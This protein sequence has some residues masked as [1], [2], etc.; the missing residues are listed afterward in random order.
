MKPHI[1]KGAMRL[2]STTEQIEIDRFN[3]W[4]KA[5]SNLH[6]VPSH[7]WQAYRIDC[8]LHAGWTRTPRAWKHEPNRTDFPPIDNPKGNHSNRQHRR[9]TFIPSRIETSMGTHERVESYTP[10]QQKFMDEARVMAERVSTKFHVPPV[11][12]HWE[13]DLSAMKG[14]YCAGYYGTAVKPWLRVGIKNTPESNIMNRAVVAHELG[15]HVDFYG[16]YRP[17]IAGAAIGAHGEDTLENEVE[18]WE[19]TKWLWGTPAGEKHTVGHRV[20]KWTRRYALETY[21]SHASKDSQGDVVFGSRK[22][23][24]KTKFKSILTTILG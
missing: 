1:I 20:G 19:T 21:M 22:H 23:Q 18:A 10:A 16:K 7:P 15:H 6:P 13:K 8:A 9:P 14:A 5:R 11:T 17:R 4:W 24:P 2:P 3:M 12:F